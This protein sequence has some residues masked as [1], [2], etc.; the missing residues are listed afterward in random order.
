MFRKKHLSAWLLSAL[1]LETLCATFCMRISTYTSFFSILYLL[2]GILISLLIIQ[3]PAARLEIR[4]REV[5]LSFEWIGKI[6]LIPLLAL[7]MYYSSKQILDST[8]INIAN[9][10]MLPV[11]KVM[12]QRFLSG[13][14]KNVYDT[15][16]GIWNGIQPIYL[17]AIWLPFAPALFFNF[18]MRWIP[19]T[20][21]F[22]AFSSFLLLVRLRKDRFASLGLLFAGALLY[23]W[24]FSQDDLHGFFSLTEEGVVVL[25]FVLLVLAILADQIL[26]IAIAASLCLLSRY[27]LIGW[28]PAFLAWLFLTKKKKQLLVFCSTGL[29]FLVFLFILPFGWGNFVRMLS[30]PGRYVQFSGI[31]WKDSPAVFTESLGLAKFFVPGHGL[32]LHGLL[33]ALS[34]TLPLFFILICYY[35]SKKKILANIPLAGLKLAVVVFYNLIDVP[36]LYL[37]YSSSF[38]S[39]IAVTVLLRAKAE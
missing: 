34:F 37:F 1:L 19:V 28:V 24:L 22:F 3:H 30:L 38:I 6:I 27:A 7:A 8:E 13:N 14:W 18:D 21:L 2:A 29:C 10:D 20:A 5:P 33:I 15:I 4:F 31:V 26:L 12:N 17:P 9:A 32:L 36:Y 23:G 25:Y 11:I 39:L 16:P 35:K